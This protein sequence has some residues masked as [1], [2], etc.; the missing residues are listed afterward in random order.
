MKLRRFN[1]LAEDRG[2]PPEFRFALL[3]IHGVRTTGHWQKYMTVPLQRAG[4]LY[5]PLDWGYHWLAPL[6]R[7]RATAEAQV[8]AVV[9]AWKTH[10]ADGLHVCAAAH[11]FGTLILGRTLQLN[12]DVRLRRI[13][14]FGSILRGTFPWGELAKRKQVTQVLNETCPD[15]RAVKFAHLLPCKWTGRSGCYGFAASKVVQNRRYDWMGHSDAGHRLHVEKVWI[16]F[17]LHGTVPPP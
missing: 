17:L 10:D 4:I 12:P 9:A 2:A 3:S 5:E 16:P 8:P 1:E 11:S 6:T 15:D 14:L 13:V 7:P